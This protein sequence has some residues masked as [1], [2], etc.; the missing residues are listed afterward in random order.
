VRLPDIRFK[1][2]FFS[3]RL[4]LT[5]LLS[6]N[7]RG[8]RP[9]A[10]F[11]AVHQ[12]TTFRLKRRKPWFVAVVNLGSLLLIS[13]GYLWM[14]VAAKTTHRAAAE[15][16]ARRH[17]SLSESAMAWRMG[18]L[19]ATDAAC[20]VPIVGLGLWSLAGLTV[21]PQVR[22]PGRQKSFR[23]AHTD[24]RL[25]RNTAP[26]SVRPF[27]RVR[28]CGKSLGRWAVGPRELLLTTV[29]RPLV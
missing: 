1:N 11:S 5:E 3:R 14:F 15:T 19:V 23:P 25:Y 21:H 24:V 9:D 4:P 12:P 10:F 2:R 6:P 18:L 16:P 17:R 8:K 28:N 26:H 27:A 13:G 29:L 22:R 20:W 7:G